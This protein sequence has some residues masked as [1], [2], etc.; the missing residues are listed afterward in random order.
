MA[1]YRCYYVND[2]DRIVGMDALVAQDDDEA[3]ETAKRLL[4]ARADR[5][6]F[7]CE[8]WEGSRRV[9]RGLQASGCVPPGSGAN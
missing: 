7:G 9:W 2:Q 6:Y 3:I 4:A 1:A 5:I 8:L